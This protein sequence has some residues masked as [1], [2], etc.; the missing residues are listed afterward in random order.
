MY[1]NIWIYIIEKREKIY[2]HTRNLKTSPFAPH[3]LDTELKLRFQ[4]R[5]ADYSSSVSRGCHSNSPRNSWSHPRLHEC[6]TRG[7]PST[8][9]SSACGTPRDQVVCRRTMTTS[10][11]PNVIVI[12]SWTSQ[13]TEL[14]TVANSSRHVVTLS[15][16]FNHVD[17]EVSVVQRKSFCENFSDF[18]ECKIKLV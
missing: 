6:M 16:S 3:P 18:S 17:T 1:K 12:K 10:S 11:T 8:F 13:D 15:S 14:C 4:S 9:F 5:R 2:I 7:F